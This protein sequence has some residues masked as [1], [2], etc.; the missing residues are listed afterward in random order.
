MNNFQFVLGPKK[1]KISTESNYLTVKHG[2]ILSYD[3]DLPVIT[4]QDRTGNQWHLMGW[5]FQTNEKLP[6]PE[7]HI[8]NI[9][10]N[11]VPQTTKDWGGRWLLIGNDQIYMDFGGSLGCFYTTIEN[12]F[13]VSSS[14]SILKSLYKIN[15][16]EYPDV[17]HTQGMDF[18]PGP[19]TKYKNILR[20]LPSQILDFTDRSIKYRPVLSKIEFT[21]YED[22]L[23][24]IQNR[25][26]TTVK[27]ISSSCEGDVILP[28][29]GG[30]D[31][32]L[33]LSALHKAGIKSSTY[34]FN[35]PF[36]N[37]TRADKTIPKLLSEEA[38]LVHSLIE[39]DSYSHE[40]LLNFEKH[41]AKMTQ[42]IDNTYYAYG[43]W[44]KIPKNS[45]IL[46][47]GVFEVGRCFYYDN[48]SADFNKAKESIYTAF[49]FATHHKHSNTHFDS[50]E[51][52]VN[53]ASGHPQKNSIDWRD[54]FYID[55]RVGSWLSS[56]EHGLDLTGIR[57][58]H[59]A[60]CHN[61]ISAFLQIPLK[62]RRTDDPHKKLMKIMSPRL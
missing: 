28:L 54:F 14:V 26:I 21:S 3:K 45:I 10:T 11:M 18:F 23:D 44:D 55:Q 31:S 35:K 9:E 39:R 49:N 41:T 30:N 12:Q 27:N 33:I 57:R 59:V 16:V 53:W 38:G 46:R 48:L 56:I 50:I 20:L 6:S 36:T 47:G 58:F 17:T 37:M 62:Y 15:V 34:T 2:H 8:K 43:Q 52:W 29:T 19:Y 60:N 61:I 25:L 32:R 24:F 7:T 51:E 4:A 22:I 13:W 42:G 1:I 5:A 40:R